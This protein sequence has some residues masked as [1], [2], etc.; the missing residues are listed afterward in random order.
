MLTQSR[1]GSPLPMRSGR[2]AAPVAF[3]TIFSA[4]VLM[5]NPCHCAATPQDPVVN[6][7]GLGGDAA[8][9]QAAI[10][11]PTV[12]NGAVI[13]LRGSPFRGLGN[14]DVDFHGKLVT[15]RS[16]YLDPAGC[17]IDLQG[18][19]DDPH[20]GFIFHTGETSQAIVDG[21]TIAN[22]VMAVGDGAGILCDGASPTIHNCAIIS[23]HA[24]SNGPGNGGG[25]EC[26][27]SSTPVIEDCVISNCSAGGRY[28]GQGGGLHSDGSSYPTLR[29][30]V[31][32]SNVARD[33]GGGIQCGAADIQTSSI[34]S[35]SAG[36]GGGIDCGAASISGCS[37]RGNSAIEYGG[38]SAAGATI[39]GSVIS[40]NVA[41]DAV[42]GLAGALAIT[43]CTITG[44]SAGYTGGV[45]A[46][47]TITQ[48]IIWGN[49]AQMYP[50]GEGG[51]YVCCDVD[52]AQLG[53]T[54]NFIGPQVNADPQFCGPADCA[55]A[56]TTAGD[57]TLQAGSPCLP[58]PSPCGALIGALTQG[59]SGPV[60]TK[61]TTWGGL[62]ALYQ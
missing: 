12:V 39:V 31:V 7:D 8:N 55:N 24:G 49:C 11:L 47:G 38:I 52:P 43:G 13:E 51:T 25:I 4:A 26:I 37:I 36:F 5:W 21:V 28:A 16:Q 61:G 58:N 42:G 15:V 23:D 3:M 50:D 22:G 20:R 56:P 59:C 17:V 57:Y 46:G 53:G 35:N 41:G 2:V 18:T 6:Y 19:D 48:T 1:L 29:N 44:N 45:S 30:C 10:D 9:I 34:H 14:K 54:P 32:S 62:K 60:P 27:N 33:L 40:G